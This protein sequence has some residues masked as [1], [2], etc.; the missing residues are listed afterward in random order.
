MWFKN[1]RLDKWRLRAEGKKKH[2]DVLEQHL[3]WRLKIAVKSSVARTVPMI[4]PENGLDSDKLELM[5]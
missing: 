3:S 4:L 2:K 1:G 5:R